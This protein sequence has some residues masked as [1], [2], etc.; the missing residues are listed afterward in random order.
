MKQT[1]KRMLSVALTVFL[2][3]PVLSIVINA[4]EEG[5]YDF[6]VPKAV[7][8]ITADGFINELEWKDA[9]TVSLAESKMTK[10]LLGGNA[11][12]GEDSYLKMMWDESYLYY[13]FKIDDPVL[14]ANAQIYLFGSAEDGFQGGPRICIGYKNGKFTIADD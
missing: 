3:M 2:L 9:L 14:I 10:P 12:I 1:L 5:T 13:A 11:K 6:N 4:Y 7:A 8:P